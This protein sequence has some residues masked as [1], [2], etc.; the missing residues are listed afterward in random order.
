MWRLE[1]N[2]QQMNNNVPDS[3][4]SIGDAITEYIDGNENSSDVAE[5][6]FSIDFRYGTCPSNK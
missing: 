4:I 6:I 1:M 5:S 3:E 2:T